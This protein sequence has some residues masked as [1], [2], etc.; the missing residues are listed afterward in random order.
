MADDTGAFGAL[1]GA[2]R[3]LAGLS[4]GELAE[5]AGLSIRAVSNLEC[6]RTAWPRPDSVRRLA[7]ALG[8][9]GEQQ[10]EFIASAKRRLAGAALTALPALAALSEAGDAVRFGVLGPLQVVDG[11]GVVKEVSAPKQRVVLATL[12]LATGSTVSAASLAEALW[13]AAPP[14]N[15][16]AVMRTYVM[17]LR[18][19]MGP[20]GARIVRRPSGWTV[21]LRLPEELDIAEVDCLWRAA[22]AAVEAGEWRQVSS[23][24]ARSLGLWR[25]EPL[26]DVPSAALAR[27]EAG[28]LSELRLQLT[29]ARIDADL[30]LGRHGELVAELRQV[31]AEHPLREHIQV[32]LML[33]CY[34][35]GDQAAALQVYRHARKTLTEELGIEP[36]RELRE[37]HQRILTADPDLTAGVPGTVTI[38][39]PDGDHKRH[40]ER[41]DE[42]PR[43]LPAAVRHFTGRTAEL[44]RLTEL[45]EE[46]RSESSPA[47]SVI[48][49]MAGVGKTAL[50]VHWSH[51]MA[52]RFADGQLYMNLRGFDPAGA[53]V[54]PAE[55]VRGFL[56]A[57]G[58]PPERIPP[59]LD[60]QA[61][62]YR[63]LL[64]G[65]H[66]MIVLDNA[67][68]EHQVRPLLPA[69][70]GCLV[71][72]TSRS[73]LAGLAASNSASL[74]TL[75]VPTFAEARQMLAVRLGADRAAAEPHTVTE[76][77][78]L[79]ARLPLALA[80]AAA[81]AAAS[82]HLP[83]AALAVELR[84][85]ADRLDALDSGD[86]VGSIRAV[87]SWSCQQLSPATARMFRLLG[88]H[89]GPSITASA[90][91]STAGISVPLA[92]SL[93]RELVRCHLL[94]EPVPG[95]YAFHDLLRAY[96]QE[97]ARTTDSEPD[98][99]EVVARLLDH[100]LH[101]SHAAALLLNPSREPIALVP[102]RHGVTPEPL[103]DSQQAVAWFEAEHQILLS[104]VALA[105]ET[106]FDAHAWQLPWA[107]AEFLD[108]RGH[109]Q[110]Y[111]VVQHTA[112]AAATRL[113]DKAGQAGARRLLA[114]NCAQLGD[115]DQARAH[116]ADC[117]GLC[118]QL[119]DRAG[120][121][122]AHQTLSWVAERQADYARSLRHAEQALA[123]LRLINDRAG[124][125]SALNNV[126]WCHAMLGDQQPAL[127]FCEQA[128]ALHRDLGNRYGEAHAWDSLGYAEHQLG[129]L[130]EAVACYQHALVNIR[131]L[132]DRYNEADTLTHLGDT[133]HT[134]GHPEAARDAWLRALAILSD[135]HHPQAGQVRAKLG[136]SLSL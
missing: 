41:E 23:L 96:A 42:V 70:P 62:L 12:L 33:A 85:T 115:Y 22:R 38:G 110:H 129:R 17:R 74:I 26:V 102:P 134:A 67:A 94:A 48:A 72:V 71:V 49:G 55:A 64:A 46:A 101:T 44:K 86:P 25:G 76:I 36:G 79:C 133:H 15:A 81:R 113:G 8:L 106:R 61:A 121:A 24:L 7:D 92:R 53:P 123:L 30:R 47:I 39:H 130:D 125:A 103:D 126:G 88:V 20:V 136:S 69:G 65:K 34:R 77:T 27:H 2:W 135:L 87:F 45:A 35:C 100:Y 32:Q 78:G 111:S 5:R 14:P 84:D 52:P 29:E 128:L 90:A 131:E 98:R 75:D 89:P 118:Q 3:R 116:L 31:T 120:E 82:S 56:D 117:V 108:R 28:R 19:A 68:D 21:E 124:Q 40:V 112:L 91:A 43:Q 16:Q 51:Q 66:M 83:L 109:W 6:G 97:Q 11:T 57:L 107:M 18:Y 37:M 122:R 63:T 50:A 104:A 95:R 119:G 9:R 1:L 54:T 13:D 59:S 99:S 93:L 4:Q 132:G 58:V 127:A 80:V 105:A 73:Q 10:D 60:A 114:H